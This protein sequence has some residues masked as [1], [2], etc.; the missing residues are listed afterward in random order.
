[1]SHP[2]LKH[3]K[4]QRE[5][6]NNRNSLLPLSLLFPLMKMS[7]Q[8][9]CKMISTCRCKSTIQAKIKPWQN[10]VWITKWNLEHRVAQYCL[11][12]LVWLSAHHILWG[13]PFHMNQLKKYKLLKSHLKMRRLHKIRCYVDPTVKMDAIWYSIA[14]GLDFHNTCIIINQSPC[15]QWHHRLSKPPIFDAAC[16]K[17]ASGPVKGTDGCPVY[18]PMTC[19]PGITIAP[20]P[21]GPIWGGGCLMPCCCI[22]WGGCCCC[23][24]G[25]CCCCCCCWWGPWGFSNF[26]N[27]W[28]SFSVCRLIRCSLRPS[29]CLSSSISWKYSWKI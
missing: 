14:F 10:T 19:D 2:L 11:G 18:P 16:S 3:D 8:E 15:P 27:Q 23:C 9:R 22:P 26:C 5:W 7:W 25:C 29:S 21:L 12:N 20:P 17:W 6:R 13:N 28:L 4:V 1:M 24:C